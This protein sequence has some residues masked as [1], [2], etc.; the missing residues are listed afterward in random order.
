[1]MNNDSSL[2]SPPQFQFIGNGSYGCVYKPD[3][4]CDGEEENTQFKKKYFISKIQFMEN[5]D[6]EILNSLN[7]LDD[8]QIE[9][10]LKKTNN[11]IKETIFGM[12][13]QSILSYYKYFAPILKSCPV[14]VG[15]L[16]LNEYEKNKCDLLTSSS[17]NSENSQIIVSSKIKFIPGG[18]KQISDLLQ[19]EEWW[20]IT[21]KTGFLIDSFRH[22]MEGIR[23]MQS[24]EDPIIHFDLKEP[25][26]MFDSNKKIPIIIDFGIS[27]TKKML[28]EF[29]HPRELENLFYSYSTTY[30]P[31]CIDIVLLSYIVNNVLLPNGK[32]T[33]DEIM[34][35]YERNMSD[36]DI[37]DLW[38]VCDDFVTSTI[39]HLSYLTGE[40]EVA[41]VIEFKK[42]LKSY[43]D[44][45]LSKP[46]KS[47]IAGLS[48][49]YLR[50][51]VYS[52]AICFLLCVVDI[53]K[54]VETGVWNPKNLKSPVLNDF[55]VLLKNI[56]LS[57]PQ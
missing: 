54:D 5:E 11:I 57:V 6:F 23:L 43:I 33:D 53:G 28:F 4:T 13:I 29:K 52:V 39:S 21:Q 49:N 1:M 17:N 50:W 14:N 56:I 12:R 38:I 37:S 15:I 2:P 20:D 45:F 46:W 24:M 9:L 3:F 48:A 41:E 22:L 25:N 19:E 26:I 40:G 36:N 7:Q 44:S 35:I 31:W 51:D 18:G 10:Q 16:K 30:S 32:N 42:K 47:L 34:K 8:E 27:F 55:Y